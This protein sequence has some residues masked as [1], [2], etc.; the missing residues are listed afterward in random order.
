M[1]RNS[2]LQ[3]VRKRTD[4]KEDVAL[5]VSEPHASEDARWF[6]D[7]AKADTEVESPSLE[8]SPDHR[9]LSK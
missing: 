1:N 3:A 9:W 6:H 5:P 8:R 7:E 2:I 4:A